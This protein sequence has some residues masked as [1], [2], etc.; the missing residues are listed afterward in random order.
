[1]DEEEEKPYRCYKQLLGRCDGWMRGWWGSDGH[2]GLIRF[3]TCDKCG[4]TS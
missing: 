2:S 4:Y 1:M 3:Y